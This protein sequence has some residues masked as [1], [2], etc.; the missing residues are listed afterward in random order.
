MSPKCAP[1]DSCYFDTVPKSK[2][3]II[4]FSDNN[5]TRQ[6]QGNYDSD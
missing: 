2:N 6:L 4:V 3:S 1:S 5:S